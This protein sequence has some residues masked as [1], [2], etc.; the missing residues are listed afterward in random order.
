MSELMGYYAAGGSQPTEHSVCFV[1][2]HP[3]ALAHE[4]NHEVMTHLWGLPEPWI[5]E[6]LAAYVSEPGE[7]DNR[8]RQLL[9]SGKAVPINRLV[10]SW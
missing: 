7:V 2:G 5:A 8:F 4:L 3:E 1:L 9:D 6:G 10:N